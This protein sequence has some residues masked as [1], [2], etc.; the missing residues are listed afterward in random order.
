VTLTA[1]VAGSSPTG[2]VNFM[3]GSTN[4]GGAPLQNGTASFNT[5][6]STKGTVSITAVYGGDSNNATSVA[7]RRKLTS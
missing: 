1:T 6:F 2:N 3:N 7:A 4:I 5:S